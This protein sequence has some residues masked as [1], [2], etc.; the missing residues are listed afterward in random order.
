MC[1][2]LSNFSPGEEVTS[3]LDGARHCL[4]ASS[5]EELYELLSLQADG[6]GLKPNYSF[7]GYFTDIT[8]GGRDEFEWEYKFCRPASLTVEFREATGSM[9]ARW[10]STWARICA[11]IVLF[12]QNAT[13]NEFH[14]MLLRL[15]RSQGDF[16]EPGPRPYDFI[17]FL[18]D[19]GLFAEAEFLEVRMQDKDQ[20]FW[21]CRKLERRRK[22]EPLPDRPRPVAARGPETI[23]WRRENEHE[24]DP[25]VE[26][27]W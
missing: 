26:E 5:T 17:D 24:N 23:W 14:S 4:R 7:F 1:T 18:D 13:A 6:C 16:G 2:T 15:A 10:V 25:H 8:R 22:P 27:M 9:D 3:A 12:A 20:A 11:G 21:P 19:I